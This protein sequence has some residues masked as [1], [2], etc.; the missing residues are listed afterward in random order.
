M[1]THKHIIGLIFLLSSFVVASQYMSEINQFVLQDKN[2]GKST[3]TINGQIYNYTPSKKL[4][5]YRSVKFDSLLI[6]ELK[7]GE[8]YYFELMDQV[9]PEKSNKLEKNNIVFITTEKLPE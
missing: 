9:S 1:K 8:Q 6:S 3:V 7:V 2:I 4:S 5:L